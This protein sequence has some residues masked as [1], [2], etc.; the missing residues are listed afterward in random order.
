MLDYTLWGDNYFA[1][2]A[3]ILLGRPVCLILGG[4]TS[5]S[6]TV[7]DSEGQ[8]QEFEKLPFCKDKHPLLIIYSGHKHWFT[9]EMLNPK[10]DSQYGSVEEVD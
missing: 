5:F 3:A 8:C 4:G 10:Q 7:Y 6:T 9:A 2:L 1:C